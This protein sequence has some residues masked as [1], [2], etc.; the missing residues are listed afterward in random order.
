MEFQFLTEVAGRKSYVADILHAAAGVKESMDV[1]GAMASVIEDIKEVYGRFAICNWNMDPYKVYKDTPK[2]PSVPAYGESGRVVRYIPKDSDNNILGQW[3]KD[4]MIYLETI[5]PG[6]EE[7]KETIAPGG[8]KYIVYMFDDTKIEDIEKIKF[9]FSDEEGQNDI[10][11]MKRQAF[12]KIND[13]WLER[14]QDWTDKDEVEFCRKKDD[15]YVTALV[16]ILSNA[17]LGAND[18]ATLTYKVDTRDK[19]TDLKGYVK[20][21]IDAI[22]EEGGDS[23]SINT[24]YYSEDEL[25]YCSDCDRYVFKNRKIS[26]EDTYAAKYL[27]PYLAAAGTTKYENT[28]TKHSGT[29]YEE[30][31]QEDKIGRLQISDD[32]KSIS[33]IFAPYTNTSDWINVRMTDTFTEQNNTHTDSEPGLLIGSIIT[34]WLDFEVGSKTYNGP[35]GMVYDE[36]E[37]TDEHIS[38]I[39]RITT[40]DGAEILLEFK[41]EIKSKLKGSD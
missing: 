40:I 34:G 31:T 27:N 5:K 29:L 2:F 17:G 10:K 18:S 12:V 11:W 33:I 19:C 16:L 15:E 14:S 20:A 13:K 9:D 41:Y 4:G 39:R 32:K 23:I 24:L 22:Y 28:Q 6:I 38:G 26:Y 8:I 21:S 3:D 25:L 37:I 1:R 30:Y 7:C 36:C 35:M